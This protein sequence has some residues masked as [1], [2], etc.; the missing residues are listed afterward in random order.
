MPG[1]DYLL[2]KRSLVNHSQAPLRGAVAVLLL[3]PGT[4][5]WGGVLGTGWWYRVPGYWVGYR[6]LHGTGIPLPASKLAWD[7]SAVPTLS[8]YSPMLGPSGEVPARDHKGPDRGSRNGIQGPPPQRYR[9][10]AS[11]ASLALV[12]VDA[13]PVRD[14]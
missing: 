1:S 8:P 7:P 4:G 12:L 3:L 10:R 11:A 2:N 9:T 5:W 6:V 13:G 14:Q